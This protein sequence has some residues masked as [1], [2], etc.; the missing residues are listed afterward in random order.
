MG[1]PLNADDQFG[2]RVDLACRPFDFTL[3]F[4]DAFFAAL[5][6]ALFL[7][8]LPLRLRSL[9]NTP[10][11][12]ISYQLASWKLVNCYLPYLILPTDPYIRGRGA[13]ARYLGGPLLTGKNTHKHRP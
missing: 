2:P 9:Y 11:K 12:V 6:A 4:E 5:P 8:L 7:L 10:V 1:C 3:L 13:L